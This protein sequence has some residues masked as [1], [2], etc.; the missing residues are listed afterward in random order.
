MPAGARQD[1]ALSI[2][3]PALKETAL[4]LAWTRALCI[5]NRAK[6]LAENSGRYSPEACT[7]VQK[8]FH[9]IRVRPRSS[10]GDGN[11]KGLASGPIRQPP[12][13]STTTVFKSR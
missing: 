2:Q 1:C 12:K 3:R 9:Q 11:N 8:D 10:A 7:G 4:G 5:F 13:F 6:V